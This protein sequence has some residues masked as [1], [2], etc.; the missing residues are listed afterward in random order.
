MPLKTNGAPK[1]KSRRGF[2]AMTAEQRRAICKLG[3]RKTARRYG[4]AH[5][6]RIGKRGRAKRAR[7]EKAAKAAFGGFKVPIGKWPGAI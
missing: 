2:A 1:P 5:M 6:S 4:K 3:G 7:N